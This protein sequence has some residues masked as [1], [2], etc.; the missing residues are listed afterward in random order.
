MK[1]MKFLNL[2]FVKSISLRS[3]LV[4]LSALL[5]I[6]TVS[7]TLIGFVVTKDIT[8]IDGSKIMKVTTTRIYVDEMLAEQGIT[9][10]NGD[11]LS[12]PLHSVLRNDDKLIIKRGKAIY[13]T[14]DGDVKE[15]HSNA[16]T[17]KEA[18]EENNIVLGALDE[19][20][21]GLDTPVVKD[22]Q[23]RI[24]RV[25]VSEDMRE[26]VVPRQTIVQPNTSQHA[27]YSNVLTEGSDGSAEVLYRVVTRDGVEISRE[28]ITRTVT[29]APVDQVVEKGILGAKTVA[30]STN[31]LKVKN[32]IQCTA[33]AYTATPNGRGGF[34][35]RTASGRPASYGVVAVDPRVIPLGTKLYIESLDGSWAYGFAIAGDTGGAIKGKKV[36]LFF[37]T[38]NECIQYGRRQIK[39]YILE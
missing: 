19:I 2:N 39:V 23:V 37:N 7:F 15:I 11:M 25:L 35:E 34:I 10:Q 30:T 12:M 31:A 28:E 8:I 32:I 29:K 5:V 22:M 20:E 1:Q 26:E 6:S 24:Y 27:S 33:T 4:I 21:P 18:L 36:D 3:V 9:L 13:V 14:V 17:L 16:S 38:Y